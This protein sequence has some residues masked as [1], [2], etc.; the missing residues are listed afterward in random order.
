MTKH[1]KAEVDRWASL[2]RIQKALGDLETWQEEAANKVGFDWTLTASEKK[3]VA[4][5]L[6]QRFRKL[7]TLPGYTEMKVPS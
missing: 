1:S 5:E 7:H 2:T 6:K 4:K 3:I